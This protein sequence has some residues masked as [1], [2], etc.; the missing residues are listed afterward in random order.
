MNSMCV[1]L[2]RA[3][4]SKDADEPRYVY[5][6]FIV[7]QQAY[8]ESACTFVCAEFVPWVFLL[9]LYLKVC[10]SIVYIQFIGC[11]SGS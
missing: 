10:I 5:N 6:I 1:Q 9:L 11:V 2:N 8:M 3:H 7:Y 4:S